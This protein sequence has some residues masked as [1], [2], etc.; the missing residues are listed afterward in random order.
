MNT[1][2]LPGEDSPMTFMIVI[3]LSAVL[4]IVAGVHLKNKDFSE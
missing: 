1:G 3:G 2:G 4:A